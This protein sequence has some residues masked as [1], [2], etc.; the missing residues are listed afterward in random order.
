MF[1][2]DEI[3]PTMEKEAQESTHNVRTYFERISCIYCIAFLY[4]ACVARIDEWS[5][6]M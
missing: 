2:W 6:K 5:S 3:V 1:F 4:P